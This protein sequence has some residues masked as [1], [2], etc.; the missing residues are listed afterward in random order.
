M[1][2]RTLYRI[3][4]VVLVV[5]AAGHTVGFLRFRPP[6]PEGVAVFEA[7][8]R[9]HF[10]VGHADFTYGSF[11]EG[12]GLFSSVYLLFCAFLSWQFGNIAVR[13]PGDARAIAWGFFALQAASLVLCVKYFFVPPVVLSTVMC[14]TTGWAALLVQRAASSPATR[15][16]T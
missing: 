9:T 7:M 15:D 16:A 8:N 1:N 13:F 6:T 3:S 5:F 11:Y 10:R 12:F 4:A 2:A 14:V